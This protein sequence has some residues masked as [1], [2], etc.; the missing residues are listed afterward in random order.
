MAEELRYPI[1]TYPAEAGGYVAEVPALEGCLVQGETLAEC[2]EEFST[3]QALWI[4]SARRNHE[5]I[6]NPSEALEKLFKLVA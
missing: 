2:L 6:P 1:T 5:D 3:V 4:E